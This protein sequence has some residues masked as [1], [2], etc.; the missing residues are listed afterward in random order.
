M[1]VV[2]MALMLW[3]GAAAGASASDLYYAGNTQSHVYP[4]SFAADG[5]LTPIPCPGTDC[6]ATVPAGVAV[7]PDGRHLYTAGYGGDISA[8]TVN[9]NGSLTR[10]P[11]P[12][13]CNPGNQVLQVAVSHDG[14][15]LYA[16]VNGYPNPVGRVAVY[17]IGTDGSLSPVACPG[18]DCD[19]GGRFPNSAVVS[20]DGQFLFVASGSPDAISAYRIDDDGT[21]TPVTCPA[22]D[23]TPGSNPVGTSI[24]PDGKHL[25]V[26]NNNS[27]SVS[28][29]TVGA[30]GSLTPIPCTPGNCSTDFAPY[31]L[32]VSPNGRFV[33]A[34]DI[35]GSIAVFSIAA[36]G[37]L[38]R[39]ACA[40]C[41]NPGHFFTG[42][43][44]AP[45]SRFVY[46]ATG[47]GNNTGDLSV[48]SAAA[49]GTLTLVPCTTC[50]TGAQ[51]N[52]QAMAI[53]PDQAP[54]AA[55]TSTPA[56]PGQATRFDGSGSSAAAGQQVARYD[57]SFGDGTTAA[58][59]GP[60]PA[61][62][63]A[64]AGRYTVTLTVT[65]DAGCS[66]QFITTSQTASCNGGPS[67]TTT[68]DVTV[69]TPPPAPGPATSAAPTARITSL[70]ASA[71]C[72]RD[73]ILDDPAS[74]G[75]RS[76]RFN[77]TLTNAAVVR[78]TVRRRNGSP[79]WAVCP[80]RRGTTPFPYT[81]VG[82][83]TENGKAGGND[84]QIGSAARVRVTRRVQLVRKR[85]HKRGRITL[86]RLLAGK[87]LKPGTYILS[88]VAL[89][90][91]GN[92]TSERHVKFWVFAPR[93][94]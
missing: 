23:C 78:L 19:T 24:T 45:S 89:D 56:P 52:L 50:N 80:A 30:D 32:Q 49:D 9:A 83:K 35:I 1:P 85:A 57:W 75:R 63:Y 42:L 31:A 10:I 3:L 88:A 66:T 68:A 46:A 64:A 27:G 34:A 76:M 7:A 11:C 28:P 15:F 33:Y 91:A 38:T 21:L 5:T 73:A 71:R 94:R 14:R 22:A 72:Y 92:A 82:S 20:P 59:A 29:F 13:A 67:A 58:D 47:L 17:A 77:Y 2:A 60:T 84:T 55:F 37:S 18:T 61:H 8:F 87:H 65:D 53:S 43:A 79:Q 26:A 81:D 74:G 51:A 54:V 39:V 69:A 12:S 44:I 40:G 70:S 25:Y 86:R 41:G 62:T 36:D 6:S 48:F 16:P 93:R 4:F 90:A